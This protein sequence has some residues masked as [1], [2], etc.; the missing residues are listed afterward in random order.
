MNQMRPREPGPIW[1]RHPAQEGEA[2]RGFDP[3]P[4]A[5][6]TLTGEG[7]GGRSCQVDVTVLVDGDLHGVVGWP[8][9][10][11]FTSYPRVRSHCASDS[12]GTV[13]DGT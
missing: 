8:A 9:S 11:A 3:T 6:A 10:G 12:T 13:P 1:R 4:D 7:A 2:R 5:D